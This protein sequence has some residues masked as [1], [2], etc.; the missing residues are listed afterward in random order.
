MLVNSNGRGH[1]DWYSF[2]KEEWITPDKKEKASPEAANQG[3]SQ[4]QLTSGIACSN[5]F[6]PLASLDEA[7]PFCHKAAL[8]IISAGSFDSPFQ[9]AA[10]LTKIFPPANETWEMNMDLFLYVPCASSH[11]HACCN[12]FGD[13]L[14][15]DQTGLCAWKEDEDPWCSLP[16]PRIRAYGR[17]AGTFLDTVQLI[18]F[19]DTV[20]SE[21]HIKGQYL[22]G[23]IA[24][25][26]HHFFV[27]YVDRVATFQPQARLDIKSILEQ[28]KHV[29]FLIEERSTD[30]DANQI[31]LLN[32]KCRILSQACESSLLLIK[33]FLSVE[34]ISPAART[35][36]NIKGE[37]TEQAADS[38]S[39]QIEFL[40]PI[41]Q[42]LAQYTLDY[43]QLELQLRSA[44]ARQV[45]HT[46]GDLAFLLYEVIEHPVPVLDPP[47][48]P[49]LLKEY[50]N[51]RQK[52]RFRVSSAYE[53]A[54]GRPVQMAK[55]ALAR[56]LE[57]ADFPELSE[58][59]EILE[60][61]NI[62]VEDIRPLLEGAE[63]VSLANA[64]LALKK[65]V[66]SLSP[67]ASPQA[68]PSPRS[69]TASQISEDS[70]FICHFYSR[71]FLNEC[72]A[73]AADAQAALELGKN[74]MKTITK[75]SQM[76]A[77][78]QIKGLVAN[79]RNFSVEAT[80]KA[81]VL[82]ADPHPDYAVK[83]SILN[84]ATIVQDI[85]K[86]RFALLQLIE[87]ISHLTSFYVPP[88]PPKK[89]GTPRKP[90]T[91]AKVDAQQ[92]TNNQLIDK[93]QRTATK[94][95]SA[96]RASI[97][98]AREGA[99]WQVEQ[100]PATIPELRALIARD[101]QEVGVKRLESKFSEEALT[102]RMIALRR[103]AGSSASRFLAEAHNAEEGGADSQVSS[104]GSSLHS[105]EARFVSNS[106]QDYSVL[107]SPQSAHARISIALAAG[108]DLLAVSAI[109]DSDKIPRAFCSRGHQIRY[110]AKIAAGCSYECHFC[111]RP[112]RKG[113]STCHC[114]T[115]GSE[116]FFACHDCLRAGASY[117][118]PPQC[119]TL[120][121]LGKC[122]RRFS[123]VVKP[124][125]QCKD[126]INAECHAWHCSECRRIAC[127]LCIP[128]PGL[129]EPLSVPQPP[130][131][132]SSPHHAC[133]PPSDFTANG[134]KEPPDRS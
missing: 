66:R 62:T 132:T 3:N 123:A 133:S 53:G 110:N 71:Q 101:K 125:S 121:C 32:N 98:P 12:S 60:L 72:I 7:A 9:A 120:T 114:G 31:Q 70:H 61:L 84:I 29:V 41:F 54:K 43:E 130:A 26:L 80:A 44:S 105:S 48:T 6:G 58:T 122:T 1:F 55:A 90:K 39:S 97:S 104:S 15:C 34:G 86:T 50:S 91:P 99:A 78:L 18:E 28:F 100:L 51:Q 106:Q 25:I 46:V 74:R 128:P 111:A 116:P 38:A 79:L 81:D 19:F 35:A 45:E 93:V 92:V 119:L 22:L 109:A 65:V 87:D 11:D 88:P 96:I 76:I 14:C 118:P 57:V 85:D 56:M 42:S 95:A 24:V 77:A 67:P 107:T 127:D 64:I 82:M 115:R 8:P 68:I 94:L 63:L 20:G 30:L 75:D 2:A 108:Q 5:S 124:C 52:L 131:S 40:H 36:L 112:F 13:C 49:R 47:M 10:P 21:L 59:T 27:H 23:R 129:V 102:D 89:G 33:P 17:L 83:S 69:L 113:L 126:K 4:G 103:D 16:P 134:R 117:R 73:M 37:P